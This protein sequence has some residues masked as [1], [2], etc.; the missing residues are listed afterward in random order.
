MEGRSD[1]WTMTVPTNLKTDLSKEIQ[2][3][4]ERFLAAGGK[5]K[6]L[7]KAEAAERMHMWRVSYKDNKMQEKS[8]KERAEKNK[9]EGKRGWIK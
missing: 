5:I 9:R 3:D 2:S 7:S 1:L 8:Y 6:E 4:V